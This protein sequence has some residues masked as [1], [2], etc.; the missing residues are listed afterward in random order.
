MQRTTLTFTYQNCPSKLKEL[1]VNAKRKEANDPSRR[2]KTQGVSVKGRHAGQEAVEAVVATAAVL[3]SG[4]KRPSGGSNSPSASRETV[5][6]IAVAIILAFLFRGFVAEAF[7]IPT[8]SMAP[9]LRGRH[10]DIVCPQ[11][12]FEY[13]TGASMENVEDGRARGEVTVACCPICNFALELDKTNNPNERSFN[14]DRILV[15]KFAYQMHEPE[16][17]DIIVFKYPGNAKQNYIKR[18]VGL[19]G[20]TLRIRHGDIHTVEN[21]KLSIVRKPPAKLK[22][23]LHVVDDTDYIAPALKK[24]GWPSRWQ[25]PDDTSNDQ[26]WTPTEDASSF[27]LNGSAEDSWLRYRHLAPR[28]SDWGAIGAGSLPAWLNGSEGTL[29]LDYYA[30]NDPLGTGRKQGSAWVGDLAVE[31]KVDVQSERGDL[32]I[33]L[34]EGGT[35]YTCRIDVSNGT[36]ELSI[37]DFDG[38][39]L[40]FDDG[41]SAR[42]AST[43]VQGIGTHNVRLANCDD[44]VLLWIDDEVIE[45]DGPTS[46]Q[47]PADVAPKWSQANPGDMSPTGI[48]GKNVS[49]TV[50]SLRVLRD[51][52]YLAQESDPGYRGEYVRNLWQREWDDVIS[53]PQTWKGTTVFADRR[54]V[55]FTLEEDQFFPLGDNS[56]ES[57][58][59]RLWSR[60]SRAGGY[61]SPP[62][63]VERELL[64]GKALVVYWP[65]GWRPKSPTLSSLTKN[66]AF[67][68]NFPQMKFIR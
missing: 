14:G 33:D 8:G 60:G 48:G 6:S 56:P 30:Y 34:V 54:T 32:L 28:P 13:N 31:A 59:A 3:I 63:Y 29:I 36:A 51:I 46:Y 57:K 2:R 42:S 41:Q 40:T 21:D 27:T 43:R 52:Y 12:D 66:F 44:Q 26:R 47:A 10:M 7:V 15:S 64:I 5:E 62:P 11:C 55:E 50:S 38:Q 68:P 61:H 53:D 67:I 20:E 23:M 4:K 35:H 24:V 9:T 25:A 65:H 1:P 45:F 17:W 37:R 19:P 22:A 39:P 18:L 49:L 16:R 58:D